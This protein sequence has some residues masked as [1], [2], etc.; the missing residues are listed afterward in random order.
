MA[1]GM[2]MTNDQFVR[3]SEGWTEEWI[4]RIVEPHS[5]PLSAFN[6][7]SHD[8]FVRFLVSW[9]EQDN[10]LADPNAA[11]TIVHLLRAGPTLRDEFLKRKL[12]VSEANGS[13]DFRTMKIPSFPPLDEFLLWVF[14][15]FDDANNALNGVIQHLRSGWTSANSRFWD[16][17]NALESLP[18]KIAAGH[19]L[20]FLSIFKNSTVRIKNKYN[21]C[22]NNKFSTE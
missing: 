15:T 13:V 16:G 12:L 2:V 4:S 22:K 6:T 11:I 3:T 8:T 20:V 19:A 9:T 17:I 14:Y 18:E 7:L 21:T 5:N 10:L 1:N